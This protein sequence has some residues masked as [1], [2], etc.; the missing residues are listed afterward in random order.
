VNNACPTDAFAPTTQVCREAADVCDLDE[1]CDGAGACAAD[2]FVSSATECRASGGICDVA[3]NCTGSDAE[4]PVDAKS[5]DECRGSNGACDLAESCNGTDNDC[6]VDAKAASG[7]VCRPVVNPICDVEENC[8]GV[9]DNCPDDQLLNCGDADGV[10]CTV[11]ACTVEGCVEQETCVEACRQPAFWQNRSGWE[12]NGVNVGYAVLEDVGSLFVCGQEL[13]NTWSGDLSS[14]LEGLCMR[15][16]GEQ[17]RKLYR[18]LVTAALNCAVSEGGTCDAIVGRFTEIDLADCDAICTNGG[19]EQEGGPSLKQCV[20]ELNCFNTGGRVIEGECQK[21]TCSDDEEVYCSSDDDC[22]AG[23]CV[24][25][26]DSCRA[27]DL[28]TEDLEAPAQICPQSG[29]ASSPKACNDART[30]GCNID[31]CY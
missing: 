5:T 23:T 10:D 17:N 27:S 22:A 30:N 25:F 11:S 3:E 20:Q 24:A 16:Q 8:D 28:C 12:S 7:T 13:N 6:P 29:P 2:A 14:I 31:G 9:S 1:Y 18:Q 15:V 19:A 21:G 26:A 4:C